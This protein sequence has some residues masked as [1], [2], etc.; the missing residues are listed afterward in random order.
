MIAG[1][2]EYKP[3][4][5]DNIAIVNLT[6]IVPMG[7]YVLTYLIINLVDLRLHIVHVEIIFFGRIPFFA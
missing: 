2:P 5:N 4:M 3:S 7:I 6:Q 1:P